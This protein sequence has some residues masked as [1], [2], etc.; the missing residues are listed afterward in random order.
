M[1]ASFSCGVEALD[2]YLQ[3]QAGQDARKRVAPPYVLL[4][5][6]GRIAGFYT[7]SA[8]NIRIDDFPPDLVKKL[9]SLVT[10]PFPQHS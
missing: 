2:R 6:D 5:E 1:R 3:Q 10:P 9:S 7:L 4:S 8:D